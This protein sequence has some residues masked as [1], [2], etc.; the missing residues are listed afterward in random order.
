MDR[1]N[2]SVKRILSL[3]E[4]RGILNYTSDTRTYE[5]KLAV[6][7]EQVGSEQNRD[8]ERNISAQ[9]VTVIKNNDNILPLKPQAGQK[10]LLLGAY[11]NETP[12]LALGMRRVIAD[13]IIS[14][15]VDYE[16]FRYTS[17]NLDQVK[18]K[19]DDADYVI[20]AFGSSARICSATVE[21]ARAEGIRLGMLRPIT[22]YPFPTRPI[23]ELAARVKGF[24]S[25]ELN[26][27]QM[28]EDVRLAV[29]GA[30]PVE[31]YG[32]Q[33]GMIYSPDEVLAALKE[34][35]IKA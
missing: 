13:H 28:V 6:A 18:Q 33:G 16:T 15:K 4:K 1:I 29:N 27:G 30:V 12:G 8:I 22:L 35:L 23:A 20:V 26:A 32:R 11:N 14:G 5:E 34:K 10:V 17:A 25:V 7:N 21:M 9:A 24:L 3:K 31:H 2:E 19:I